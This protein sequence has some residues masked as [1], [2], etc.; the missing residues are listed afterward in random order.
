MA[1]AFSLLRLHVSTAAGADMR[2]F[3]VKLATA[4]NIR[5]H[6]LVVCGG[7]G[8]GTSATVWADIRRYK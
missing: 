1:L 3:F 7:A 5:T 4:E 2:K 6:L 8:T